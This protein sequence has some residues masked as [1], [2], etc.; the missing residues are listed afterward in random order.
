M[1]GDMNRSGRHPSTHFSRSQGNEPSSS[2]DNN[3]RISDAARRIFSIFGI[4]HSDNVEPQSHDSQVCGM[5]A[6]EIGRKFSWA[7]QP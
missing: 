4:D 2:M 5:T 1:E 6:E 3:S 7:A